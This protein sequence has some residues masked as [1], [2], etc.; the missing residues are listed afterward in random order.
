MSFCQEGSYASGLN[1]EVQ[2]PQGDGDDEAVIGV[3]LACHVRGIED[4]INIILSVSGSYGEWGIPA[5]C[6]DIHSDYITGFQL[7]VEKG[8]SDDSAVNSVAGYCNGAFQGNTS[9]WLESSAQ[10]SWGS[11][12]SK[13]FC[14]RGTAVCGITVKDDPFETNRAGIKDVAMACCTY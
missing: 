4:S 7:K 14:P 3:G 6:G 10:G 9:Y 13:A 5:Y 11:W 2:P 1:Q 12:G 8:T